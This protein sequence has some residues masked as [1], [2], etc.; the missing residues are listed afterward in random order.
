MN[1]IGSTT[2]THPADAN[3]SVPGADTTSPALISPPSSNADP[4]AG[5]TLLYELMSRSRDTNLKLGETQV[6]AHKREKEADLAREAKAV[7]DQ[8]DAKETAATWGVFSKVA[9]VVVTVISAVAACFTCGAASGLLVASVC[10]SAMAFAEQQ[11]HVVGTLS[12][13]ET[14]STGTSIGLGVAA[15][16]CSLGA[17]AVGTG[18]QAAAS[19]GMVVTGCSS[20]ASK[21][22]VG[23]AQIA[24][25]VAQVVQGAT[26]IGSAAWNYA[27]AEDAIDGKQAGQHAAKMDRLVG[28]LIDGIKETS[29]SHDRALQTL[30]GAINTNGQTLVMAS[31]M[32]V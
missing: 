31:S 13:S 27:S 28:W 14:A 19:V 25:G 9:S 29:K 1:P 16:I 12:G 5:M 18:A 26:Q 24:A 21:A 30:Q 11:F 17:S 8:E 32:R 7:A 3:R 4:S 23:G 2:R 6:L 20:A 15:A 10:L 22:V